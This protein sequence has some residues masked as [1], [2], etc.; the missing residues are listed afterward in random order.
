MSLAYLP[1][2]VRIKKTK[3][4]FK[5]PEPF[6]S[7]KIP[8]KKDFSRPK[9]AIF[10]SYIKPHG[11]AFA[12]DMA[13]SVGIALVDLIF[14]YVS[15][16]SMRSLLPEGLFRTFFTVMVSRALYLWLFCFPCSDVDVNGCLVLL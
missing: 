6:D 1:C 9:L 16:W 15:R 5:A 4:L 7:R 11:K 13:L 3:Q 12:I 8:M 14:P 10:A 2:S